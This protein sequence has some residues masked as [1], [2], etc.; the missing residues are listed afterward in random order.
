MSPAASFQ[1]PQVTMIKKIFSDKYVVALCLVWALT[2][3]IGL[4]Y[5][6]INIS[7]L[8][9][10]I[11][12]FYSHIWGEGQLANKNYIFLP[13]IA[14]FLFGIINFVITLF[15]KEEDKVFSYLLLATAAC[16]SILT[17]ITVVNIVNLIS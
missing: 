9:S 1:N 15:I 5:V 10:Q 16:L 11:P 4:I 12:L 2:L 3:A 13:L 7:N 6:G 17:T 14:T 8:P